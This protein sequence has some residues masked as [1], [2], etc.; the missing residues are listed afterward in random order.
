MKRKQYMLL[1]IF[2][3]LLSG[4]SVGDE[5]MDDNKNKQKTD[6]VILEKNQTVDGYDKYL[7][8]KGNLR[9]FK[10]VTQPEQFFGDKADFSK[11][12]LDNKENIISWEDKEGNYL[13]ISTGAIYYTTKEYVDV[14]ERLL[15][16]EHGKF[17]DNFDE[18]CDNAIISGMSVENAIAEIENIVNKNG[19]NGRNTKVY[20]LNQEVLTKL[21]KMF[22]SDEEYISDKTNEPLKREFAES[23]AAYLVIMDVCV[24]QYKLY[25][26]SYGYGKNL[27]CGSELW[28]IVKNDNIVAFIASEI[29]D[30]DT[31]TTKLENILSEEEAKEKLI[32]KY[33]NIITDGKIECKNVDITYIAWTNNIAKGIYEF[34]PAYVFTLEYQENVSKTDNDKTIRQ[35]AKIL[36][37]AENG[38]WIE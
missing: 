27:Y 37:D 23:D 19:I 12:N 9:D 1:M 8:L 30:I 35:R 16:D 33:R 11:V 34:I 10:E 29:Y 21:S 17:R 38:K 24:E 28:G 25:N 18:I 15:Y 22:M 14:Y 26:D 4:C 20:A 6:N 32:K 3:I 5:G 13:T 31:T 7:S 2:C 36:L